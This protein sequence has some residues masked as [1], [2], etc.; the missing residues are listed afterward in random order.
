[1][2]DYNY[3]NNAVVE[4]IELAVIKII[5]EIVLFNSKDTYSMVLQEAKEKEIIR[6]PSTHYDEFA[7]LMVEILCVTHTLLQTPL[8]M[9]Q[10]KQKLMDFMNLEKTFKEISTQ[11]RNF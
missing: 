9:L 11:L 2:K 1:M 6:T 5:V 10:S 4:I 8:Q 3:N 7:M